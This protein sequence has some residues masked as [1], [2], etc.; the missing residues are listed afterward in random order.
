MIGFA[1]EIGF[2][3]SHRIDHVDKFNLPAAAAE[4][5]SEIGG[6]VAARVYL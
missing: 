4:Q 3:G 5:K 2:V 6:E 1:K